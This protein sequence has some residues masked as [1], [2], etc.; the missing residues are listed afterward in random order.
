MMPAIELDALRVGD[1]D[2]AL[3]ER[4]GLAVERQHALS[5][6]RA[7]HRQVA[8]DL[9]EV[10]HV[11]RP[12]AVEG[13]VIGDVDQRVD[14]PQPDRAQALLHPFGRRSVPHAAH[15]AEREGRAE[16][17]VGGGEIETHFRRAVEGADD[18]FR[19]RR[20]QG[21]EPG[22][23]EVARDAGYAGRV[24]P[25][26]RQGDVDDR[27]VEPGP[28]RVRDADRR[29]VRQLDDAFDGRR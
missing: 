28:A 10:E 13:D 3:V 15:E 27:I 7:P 29:V 18:R 12:A 26:R 6:A 23:G 21:P 25:V 4:V 14:R 19:R 11:Q 24:G 1:D 9:G 8:L 17:R 5:R 16:M 22:R 20:P 2:H